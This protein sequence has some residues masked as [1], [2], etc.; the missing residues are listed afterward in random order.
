MKRTVWILTLKTKFTKFKKKVKKKNQ[1]SERQYVIIVLKVIAI[2]NKFPYK[3]SRGAK[4]ESD[5]ENEHLRLKSKLWVPSQNI[6]KETLDFTTCLNIWH[7]ITDCRRLG[8]RHMLL[9]V[10]RC[11]LFLSAVPQVELSSSVHWLQDSL[12]WGSLRNTPGTLGSFCCPRSLNTLHRWPAEGHSFL[13]RAQKRNSDLL[14]RL[15]SLCPFISTF[16]KMLP[17]F[18]SF[19]LCSPLRTTC[20]GVCAW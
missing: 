19:H 12:G 15:P 8:L 4:S 18:P 17:T 1:N 16:C 2:K 7:C 11:V 10:P 14:P 6:L 9:N 5:I 20:S 3:N 13:L